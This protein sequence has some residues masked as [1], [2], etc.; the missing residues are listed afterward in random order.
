[1]LRVMKHRLLL[2]DLGQE[3]SDLLVDEVALGIPAAGA[4]R[5]MA[6]V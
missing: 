1:M 2:F 3:Q 6:K 4:G 5:T